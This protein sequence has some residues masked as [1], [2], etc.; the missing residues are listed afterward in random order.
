MENKM[1]ETQRRRDGG[2]VKVTQRQNLMKL[3]HIRPYSLREL[4]KRSTEL[5]ER[6]GDPKLEFTHQAISKWFRGISTPSS[7]GREL[8]ATVYDISKNDIDL[9]CGIQPL[10]E[11]ADTVPIIVNVTDTLGMRHEYNIGIR[12]DVDLSRSHIL[13]DWSSLLSERPGCINRHLRSFSDRLC[14]YTPLSIPPYINH[15]KAVVLLETGQ[16]AFDRLESP[17]KKLWFAYLP[18]GSLELSYIF[19]DQQGRHVI[20]ARPGERPSKWRTYH[21][22]QIDRVGYVGD[23]VLFHMRLLQEN[24]ENSSGN[25]EDK[26]ITRDER[27]CRTRNHYLNPSDII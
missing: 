19:L 6:R 8:L 9:H 10:Q 27:V 22:D 4:A 17:E 2:S 3:R 23:R 11:E 12:P 21:K 14:G 5:A 18:D 1:T 24:T 20:V 16:K 13:R 26:L 15:S 25:I 7:M